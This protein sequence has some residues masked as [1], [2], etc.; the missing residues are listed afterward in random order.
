[1]A[2]N[3]TKVGWD[4][5]KYVNPTNMNQMDDGIKAACDA[6]DSEV[7]KLTAS[8]AQT[9]KSAAAGQTA[10]AISSG[11][12]ANVLLRFDSGNT[13]L[14][15]L[16][17]SAGSNKPVFYDNS[18]HEIALADNVIAKSSTLQTITNTATGQYVALFLKSSH[19]GN[20]S[21]VGF[22]GA[23]GS[24][25]GYLGIDENNKPVYQSGAS[26][27]STKEIALTENVAGHTFVSVNA[28]SSVTITDLPKAYIVA[29]TNP[30]LAAAIT[31][32]AGSGYGA[33]AARH[34]IA[35]IIETTSFTFTALSSAYGLIIQNNTS[36][37]AVFTITTIG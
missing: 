35:P 29:C 6:I 11:S 15:F 25:L 4:T 8:S 1:M 32:Y 3:Y 30:S 10:L 27:S 23:S 18:A 22:Q 12:T 5:S 26:G 33:T 7:V 37:Q 24:T 28:N 36:S 2:I 16:G 34:K 9:I 19:S 17:V 21:F 31:V 20:K 13:T 14:G